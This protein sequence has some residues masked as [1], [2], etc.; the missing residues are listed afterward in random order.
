MSQ[1]IHWKPRLA[2]GLRLQHE[3]AQN[4]WVLLYA[5]GMVKLNDSAAE[6]LRRCDGAHDV[7]AIVSELE[8]AFNVSG[9][10]P[11]VT[12][13]TQEGARRGWLV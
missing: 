12:N 4:A 11:E 10:A 1:D 3:A 8:A 13:L 7:A 9:I 2:D 5:E 6:I